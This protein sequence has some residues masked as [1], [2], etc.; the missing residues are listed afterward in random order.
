MSA[1]REMLITPKEAWYF[2]ILHTV[3]TTELV[4]L[5]EINAVVYTE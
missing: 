4:A 1:P 2:N 5:I 3:N